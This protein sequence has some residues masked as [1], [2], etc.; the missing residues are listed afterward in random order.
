MKTIDSWKA[1]EDAAE[2]LRSLYRERNIEWDPHLYLAEIHRWSRE[3]EASGKPDHHA[4][5]TLEDLLRYE[6]L[7]ERECHLRHP[8]CGDRSCPVCEGIG[9][10]GHEGPGPCEPAYRCNSCMPDLGLMFMPEQD[11]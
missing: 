9:F 2:S 7:G 6:R 11:E 10:V 5:W 3:R 1:E 8:G 4:R